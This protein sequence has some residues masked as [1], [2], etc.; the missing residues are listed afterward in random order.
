[1]LDSI[2]SRAIR[3]ASQCLL[4]LPFLIATS[5]NAGPYIDAGHFAGTM[6]GWATAV[7]DLV[8]GPVDIAAPAG[9]LASHGLPAHVLG[10][11]TGGPA[12]I[13]SLGDG[14]SITVI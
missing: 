5:V 11:A 13:L 9:P 1:M 7:D 8:R 3:A 14:G 4:A 2:R 10:A 12:D 6:T